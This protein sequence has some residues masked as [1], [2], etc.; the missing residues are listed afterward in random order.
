[1]ERIWR[2]KIT[3]GRGFADVAKRVDEV[4]LALEKQERGWYVEKTQSGEV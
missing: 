1:M 4:D 2:V 3:N